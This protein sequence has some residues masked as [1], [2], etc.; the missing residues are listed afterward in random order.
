MAELEERLV[1]CQFR[2]HLLV[3]IVHVPLE[4]L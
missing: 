3:M 4:T 2:S 1:I